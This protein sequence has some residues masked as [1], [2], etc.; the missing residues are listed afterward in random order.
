[1]TKKEKI[2]KITEYKATAR[3]SIVRDME[4]LG[5]YKKE[6]EGLIDMYADMVAQYNIAWEEFL[7]GGCA[8]ECKTKAGGIRKTAAITTMEE[9]RRQIG[10]YADRLCISPKSRKEAEKKEGS[11]LE[12]VF[13]E[14]RKLPNSV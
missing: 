1:M 8:T 9:L 6:Y 10:A 14:I 4:G 13:A 12:K 2:Q 11:K 3:E 7:A 5:V